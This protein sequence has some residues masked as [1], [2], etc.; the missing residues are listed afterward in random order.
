MHV[1]TYQSKF[2]KILQ[3]FE[4]SNE[5][6]RLKSFEKQH[7]L[8]KIICINRNYYEG[9]IADF[10]RRIANQGS[11][12]TSVHHNLAGFSEEGDL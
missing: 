1:W 2:N 11:K 6:T 5:R 4:V 9:N 7:I 3:G 12:S 10:Q 8:K